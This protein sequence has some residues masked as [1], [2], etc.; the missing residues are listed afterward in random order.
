MDIRRKFRVFRLVFPCLK[1][2]QRIVKNVAIELDL[3]FAQYLESKKGKSRSCAP[4]SMRRANR[5]AE[6]VVVNSQEYLG[7]VVEVVK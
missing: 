5:K 7:S 3:S 4:A 1:Q 6:H 2:K